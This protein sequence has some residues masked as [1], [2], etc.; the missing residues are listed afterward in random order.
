MGSKVMQR[1][2]K[3]K[4]KSKTY[5]LQN[6]LPRKLQRA[7]IRDVT[8]NIQNALSED[9][10]TTIFRNNLDIKHGDTRPAH[11]IHLRNQQTQPTRP[12]GDDHDLMLEIDCAR[13]AVGGTLVDNPRDEEDCQGRCIA[14][15]D[16]PGWVC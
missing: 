13:D 14:H 1:N 11:A 10:I 12:A 7:S 3:R 16:I 8:R 2:Q 5:L 6:P 4:K 15:G 9:L